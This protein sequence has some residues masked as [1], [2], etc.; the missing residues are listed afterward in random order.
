MLLYTEVFGEGEPIVF[1][2]TGLQT[3]ILD[4]TYQREYFES[5][6]QVILPDLRGHGKSSGNVSQNYFEDC[7]IDLAETLDEL[8]IESAHIAGCS[9]GALA[10]LFFAKKYPHKVKS[11]ALSGVTAEKPDNW[12]EL[13]Q[14][15]VDGQTQLL[16]NEEAVAYFDGLHPSDWRQFIYMARDASWYPFE[17]TGNLDGITS[18]VLYMVGEGNKSETAGALLYPEMRKDVHVAI[19][20]FAAHLVHAEQPVIY[21]KIL[22]EFLNNIKS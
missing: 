5:S 6:Y 16:Q 8:N 4:Y 22:E 13:H 14:Q 19:I 2:H 18:P 15:D 12:L 10:G 1:L 7:A 17:E 9:L 11:L 3:G 21:T 20:P